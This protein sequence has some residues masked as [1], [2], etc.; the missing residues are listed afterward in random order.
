MRAVLCTLIVPRELTR[1]KGMHSTLHRFSLDTIRRVT[2]VYIYI[3][4]YICIYIYMYMYIHIYTHL[5]I[6]RQAYL[7]VVLGHPIGVRWHIYTYIYIY[8]Y[9]YVHIFIS[10]YIYICIYTDLYIHMYTY[11]PIYIYI[12]AQA[13]IALRRDL[14]VNVSQYLCYANNTCIMPIVSVLRQ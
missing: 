1:N 7:A 6:Q 14:R 11:T 8:I 3:Y 9:A 4:I 10:I 5:R 12:Y 2:D 13:C